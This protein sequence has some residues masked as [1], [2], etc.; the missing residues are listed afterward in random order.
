V[1]QRPYFRQWGRIA[2]QSHDSVGNIL[3]RFPGPIMLRPSLNRC[4]ILLLGYAAGMGLGF[5][6]V[7]LGDDIGWLGA[8]GIQP[9]W[10]GWF[11]VATFGA[12]MLAGVFA[13]R[14]RSLRLDQDGFEIVSFIRRRSVRWSD[15]DHFEAIE[16]YP[17][18]KV[19]A[20]DISNARKGL[21]ALFLSGHTHALDDTF[22]L[23][24]AD[25]AMLMKEWR[26]RALSSNTLQLS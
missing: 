20:F 3:L 5:L 24:A 15:V 12:M 16:P 18:M 25:L 21:S 17:W 6:E 23:H 19:V 9:S 2:V 13:P 22:G 8:L 14:I 26:E 11:L 7:V 10:L 1:A 4:S